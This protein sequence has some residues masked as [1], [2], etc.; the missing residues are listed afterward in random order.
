MIYDNLLF[1]RLIIISPLVL[2]L[3]LPARMIYNVQLPIA[4]EKA[5]ETTKE[6]EVIN[7]EEGSISD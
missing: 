7:G 3:F 5:T 6:K 2:L 1:N 4:L